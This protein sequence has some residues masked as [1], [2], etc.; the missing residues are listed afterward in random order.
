MDYKNA[1]RGA[2]EKYIELLLAWNE[3]I[4]LV[5]IRN[6]QELVDRHILDS[7]QLTNYI[8][9]SE[10]VYDIGSGAGFP[11]LMLSFA[12]IKEVNLVEKVKK[13]ADFLAVARSISENKVNIHNKNVKEMKVDKCDVITARG[14]ASLDNVLSLTEGIAKKNTRYILLKGKNIRDEIKKASEKW[15]FQY[16]IHK[17][18]TSEDGGVLELRHNDKKC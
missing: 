18:Q 6:K 16:I 7:L 10:I 13:K 17:S 1:P 3:K 15:S 4:N 11:G 9:E 12:G 14:L 2:I 5:S 8:K